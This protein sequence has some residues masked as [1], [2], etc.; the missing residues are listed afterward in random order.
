[1]SKK[2]DQQ[3]T[4]ALKR[5]GINTPNPRV[6]RSSRPPNDQCKCSLCGTTGHTR[7]NCPDV[8]PEP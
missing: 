2:L 7:R 5:R 6:P 4:A 3:L 1:M 8:S